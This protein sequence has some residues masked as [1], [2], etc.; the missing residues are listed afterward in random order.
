MSTMA[1]EKAARVRSCTIRDCASNDKDG[2]CKAAQIDIGKGA[3]SG[4][5][6]CLTYVRDDIL[7][8]NEL[9]ERVQV[10]LAEAPQ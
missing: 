10:M 9:H 7:L 1:E 3:N 5:M 2:H 6:T 4:W 8:R